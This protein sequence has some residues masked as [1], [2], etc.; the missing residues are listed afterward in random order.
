M[1]KYLDQTVLGLRVVQL[2]SVALVIVGFIWSTSDLL[3]ATILVKAPV[4]PL[5]VLFMLYGFVGAFA[6]EATVRVVRRKK[7]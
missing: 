6:S 1:E 3:L 4:T 7:G 2:L 5:S